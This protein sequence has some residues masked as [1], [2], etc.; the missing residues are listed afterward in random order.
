VIRWLGFSLIFLGDGCTC[1][2]SHLSFAAQDHLSA[3][4]TS[5]R[6]C[7]ARSYFLIGPV[8]FRTALSFPRCRPREPYLNYVTRQS[9]FDSLT[10]CSTIM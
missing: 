8:A 10:Y 2:S 3:Y 6:L 5:A 4:S 1:G 7:H 9:Q